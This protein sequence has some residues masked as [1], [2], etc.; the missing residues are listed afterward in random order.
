M[1]CGPLQANVWLAAAVWTVL[2]LT[3]PA[4]DPAIAHWGLCFQK[5]K[6]K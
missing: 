3:L 1:T 5:L 4:P 2:A 6:K